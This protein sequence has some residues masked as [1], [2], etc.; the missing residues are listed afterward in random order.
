MTHNAKRVLEIL[1][2]EVFAG[3][4]NQ[5]GSSS[6][7]HGVSLLSQG[8]L[9]LTWGWFVV[10]GVLL[11]RWD[12]RERRLPNSLVA[13][14]LAGGLLGFCLVSVTSGAWDSLA[15]ALMAAL[16]SSLVFLLVY[17]IGGMG[18]GDVKYAAVI[19]L[20]LGWLGWHFVYWG[21]FFGFVLAAVV[22]GV[23]WLYKFNLVSL[24]FGPFMTGGAL[25][26]GMLALAG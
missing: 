12:I 20:Y 2:D 21:A 4:L 17:L 26:V 11:A 13:T 16:V 5:V 23:M 14:S 9:V 8:L 3:Q 6:N 15:R 7:P 1:A 25:I 10:T 18:M 19:G 22:G 24:P